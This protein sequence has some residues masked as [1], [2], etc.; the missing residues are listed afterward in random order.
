MRARREKN[1]KAIVL[2]AVSAP[3]GE[4]AAVENLER[5]HGR[6]VAVE[7]V[8]QLAPG[9]LPNVYALQ[10]PPRARTR[11]LENVRGVGG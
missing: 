6:A 2:L 3:A 4:E 5:L 11:G 1:N 9:Q 7:D 8:E 10:P